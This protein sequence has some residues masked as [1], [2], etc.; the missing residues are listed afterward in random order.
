[1]KTN[2][3][4]H[5]ILAGLL[6]FAVGRVQTERNNAFR[7]GFYRHKGATIFKLAMLG[8]FDRKITSD[9]LPARKATTIESGMDQKRK[10][11]TNAEQEVAI[12]QTNATKAKFIL[13]V[14]GK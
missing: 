5:G 2:W 14:H 3:L 11:S 9:Q 13:M 6:V 8:F 7:A 4:I 1:M 10:P 12:A